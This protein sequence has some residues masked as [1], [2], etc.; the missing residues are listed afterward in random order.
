MVGMGYIGRVLGVIAEAG[1]RLTASLS[2]VLVAL[3]LYLLLL[4]ALFLFLT[5]R[6][7]SVWQVA[8]GLVV[9]PLAA[10]LIF[11]VA[12]TFGLVAIRAGI[13]TGYKLKRAC[14]DSSKLIVA[15]LPLLAI[16]LGVL[17]GLEA[18]DDLI[19][20]RL[21][22]LDAGRVDWL[23]RS[24]LGLE[25][26]RTGLLWVVFPLLA[27]HWWILAL[28]EGA[29]QALW[30]VRRV[31]GE[32]FNP[33]SILVYLLTAGFYGVLAWLLFRLRP[34]IEREW[35]ELWLFGA[36]MALAL[37]VVFL[38]WLLTLGSLAVWTAR[39]ELGE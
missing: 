32:A 31:F 13:D 18:L 34:T 26:V 14:V 5:T 1:R 2:S 3:L 28:R 33:G 8:M 35:L 10:V 11:F 29:W 20:R 37:L 6:E 12:Q 30:G 36:R 19:V 7:S 15:T 39:G 4:G 27:V 38:G 24:R 16:A 23:L 17:Y 22:A 25:W 9:W 21:A